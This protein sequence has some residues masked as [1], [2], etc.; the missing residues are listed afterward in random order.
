MSCRFASW[1][2]FNSREY[3]SV[4]RYSCDVGVIGR[5]KMNRVIY[6]SEI[7]TFDIII[8]HSHRVQIR[9]MWE[10]SLTSSVLFVTTIS[11]LV[12]LQILLWWSNGKGKVYDKRI[13]CSSCIMQIIITKPLS[14]IRWSINE[15]NGSSITCR[16]L[17]ASALSWLVNDKMESVANN[18][19]LSP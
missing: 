17:M 7:F 15:S 3:L 4:Q 18:V 10:S 8:I 5:R 13:S 12:V 16:T 14:I 6:C 19:A 1:A 11:C 9:H 2:S